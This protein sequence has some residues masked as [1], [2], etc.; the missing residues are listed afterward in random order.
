VRAQ[1]PFALRI[2][3]PAVR[4][5]DRRDITAFMHVPKTAGTSITRSLIEV[6]QPRKAV[7]GFDRV[8]FG[9]FTSFDTLSADAM[10]Y[11][12]LT[13]GD[14]PADADFIGGHFS[15]HTLET[16]Y[17]SARLLTVVREPTSRLLSHWA[18]WRSAPP[19]GNRSWGEWAKYTGIAREPLEEFLTRPEIACQTDNVLARMLLFPHAAISSSSFIVE[20]CDDFIIQA[21]IQKLDRFSFTGVLEDTG[22]WTKLSAYVGRSVSE[23]REKVTRP[24]PSEFRTHLAEALSYKN[25]EI[26]QKRSRLDLRLWVA[27]LNKTAPEF[28]AAALRER[29]FVQ[30]ALRCAQ[31]LG[32]AAS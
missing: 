29:T 12:H 24:T 27:I 2:A 23:K 28:D 7:G 5:S 21:C 9:G 14:L 13:H 11:V 6:L 10:Q 30:T 3:R 26:M 17:P 19:G 22:L 15:L 31:L 4:V 25:W 32:G 16:R 18:F 8:L 20:A 1:H